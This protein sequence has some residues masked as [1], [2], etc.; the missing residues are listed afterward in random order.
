MQRGLQTNSVGDLI[1][2]TKL[3]LA[4]VRKMTT[5]E[6]LFLVMRYKQQGRESSNQ[7]H[8]HYMY[9]TATTKLQV[10]MAHNNNKALAP[11][12]QG[13]LWILNKLVWV[14]HMDKWI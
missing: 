1:G 3:D 7:V 11:N 6:L 14:G 9:E 4:L 12:F 5:L 2:T 10:V 13:W 8:R